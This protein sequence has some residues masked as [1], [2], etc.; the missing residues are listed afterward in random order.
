[1]IW[2]RLAWREITNSPRFT[3]FFALNIALGLVGFI[4]VDA[5]KSSIDRSLS[6]KSREI[7]GADFSISAFRSISESEI[8]LIDSLMPQ[9]TL[10]A[11]ESGWV[12]MVSAAGSTH[13]NPPPARLMEI[14]A[15]DPGFPFYGQIQFQDDTG[16][17]GD[18]DIFRKMSIEPLAIAGP[19]LFYQLGL[20]PGAQIRVGEQIFKLAGQITAD[21]STSSAS[22]SIAPRLYIG[23]AFA[24]D[25]GLIQLGSRVTRAR[26]YRLPQRD[27][28]VRPL[29]AKIKTAL[30]NTNDI[31]VRS[32]VSATDEM[33]RVLKFLG[34]YLGVVAIIAI[35]LAGIGGNYLIFAHVRTKIRDL[36]ILQAIGALPASTQWITIFQMIIM[37][38]FGAGMA[39]VFAS[40]SIPWLRHLVAPFLGTGVQI[41]IQPAS[42]FTAFTLGTLGA[43]I[44]ALPVFRHIRGMNARALF[45]E[46]EQPTAMPISHWVLPS[47]PSVGIIFSLAAWQTKSFVAASLFLLITATSAII[48]AIIGLGFLSALSLIVATMA[49]QMKSSASKKW[50]LVMALR[51]MSRARQTTLVSFVTMGLCAALVSS[52]P[53]IRAILTSE[54][55]TSGRLPGLFLFDIQPAQEDELREWLQEKGARPDRFSPMIRARLEEIN[56]VKI[57]ETFDNIPGTRERD[58]EERFKNRTYNLSVRGRLSS[59]EELSEG[60]EFLTATHDPATQAIPE[61]SIEKRFSE[62]TGI[63]VGDVLLFNIQGVPVKGK[64][65]NLRRVKWTSF[66][67]NFFVQF[68]EGVIDDA[69]RT[70]IGT[71]PDMGFETTQGLQR[72]LAQKFPNISAVDVKSTVTRILAISDQASLAI[73]VMAIMCLIAGLAVLISITIQQSRK[74]AFE[75][76]ILKVLGASFKAIYV[77]TF[78]EAALIALFASFCGFAISFGIAWILSTFVFDGS[79]VFAVKDAAAPAFAILLATTAVTMVFSRVA[80]GTKARSLLQSALD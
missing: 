48:L 5:L 62:R 22:F 54:L 33:A 26:L 7:L 32:H 15:V 20:L 76:A 79:W 19:E 77:R 23:R 30:K 38:A 66:Q 74:R 68:Q 52:V 73:T 45:Q 64:V 65:V 1:M 16:Q 17:V 21:P 18:P 41:K 36:A 43:P 14:R 60:R 63:K 46:H 25:T 12:S 57:N 9:G 58:T 6:G 71:V 75:T 61:I 72:E 10:I 53:Q 78:C 40:V 27:F 42:I 67:P 29:E 31:R 13:S 39:V 70:Y 8:N 37:G 28:D 24:E 56:N 69:P 50:P 59:S 44:A 3:I 35:L 55:K 2:L 47:L 80:L 49:D 4:V 11:E 51:S 34:D